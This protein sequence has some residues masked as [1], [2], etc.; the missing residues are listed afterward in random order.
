MVTFEY[1]H[2]VAVYTTPKH[3]ANGRWIVGNVHWRRATSSTLGSPPSFLPKDVARTENSRKKQD[4]NM[5]SDDFPVDLFSLQ[6]DEL[7]LLQDRA[8]EA[9]SQVLVGRYLTGMFTPFHQIFLVE[10]HTNSCCLTFWQNRFILVSEACACVIFRCS[11]YEHFCRTAFVVA[12]HK[13]RLPGCMRAP[14]G[15]RSVANRAR[16]DFTRSSCLYR[17]WLADDVSSPDEPI[18]ALIVTT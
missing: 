10:C 15:A 9:K 2:G 1:M 13:I 12:F 17:C 16:R 8:P 5:R 3:A 18:V 11:Q 7:K 14:G 6:L 4:R